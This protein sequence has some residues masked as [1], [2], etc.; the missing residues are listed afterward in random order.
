MFDL[1]P[2]VENVGRDQSTPTGSRRMEQIAIGKGFANYI[3]F[4]FSVLR[5]LT[6][7]FV[8]FIRRLLVRKLPF[9]SVYS[10]KNI[11]RWVF[12]HFTQKCFHFSHSLI[13]DLHTSSPRLTKIQ[14]KMWER[15]L[16]RT[17]AIYSI[18]H[19]IVFIILIAAKIG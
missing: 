1:C 13:A 8:N 15:C 12:D 11:L 6:R 7:C 16:E 10:T 5:R 17:P 3:N 14:I 4:T 19:S 2:T 9:H 18:G